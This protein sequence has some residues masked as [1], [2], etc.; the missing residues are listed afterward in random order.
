[1]DLD[2]I[3]DKLPPKPTI[4]YSL[5]RLPSLSL[6]PEEVFLDGQKD[7]AQKME[8]SFKKKNFAIFYV[9]VILIFVLLAG[10]AGWLQVVRGAFYQ[11]QAE[12][13]RT[14]V[15][16]ILAP[17]GIIY[18]RNQKQLVYNVP[19]FDAVAVPA[20]LPK[21]KAVREELIKKVSQILGKDPED[22]GQIIKSAEFFSFDPIIIESDIDHERAVMLEVELQNL[23]GI[24][25]EK[26]LRREYV[27]APSFSHILGYVGRMDDNDIKA[28]QDY[29]LTETVGKNGLELWYED[30]LHTSPGR[31]KL[32]VDAFGSIKKELDSFEPQS[33]K[34][35]VLSIDVDLQKFIYDR[36]SK[37]L[38]ELRLSKAAA[39]ALNPQNGQIMALASLPGFDSNLLAGGMGE[40]EYLSFSQ[41]PE[42]PLFNRAI[43]GQYPPGS[44]I[45]PFIGAA[46]LEEKI[47]SANT[48]INDAG[49]LFIGSYI[50][51]DWKVHG[52]VNIYSA[53]AQSCNVFF[54]HVGG[55]YG[56]FSGLGV[57]GLEKYLKLFGFGRPTGIDLPNEKDGFVPSADWKKEK[58]G[59][60][61][62]IGDTYHLSIGQGDITVT[63]LQ[64]AALTAVI[65]NSGTIWQPQIVDKIVDAEKNIIE[66]IKP[67]GRAADFISVK[68]L[69]IIKEA[70][71]QT[72]RAGS[73]Q[74]LKSLSIAVAGK[75]GTAQTSKDKK[76]Q[77]WFTSFAPFDKPEIVLVIL[78]EEGG[79]GS[80]VAVPIAKDVLEWYFQR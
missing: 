70:M 50:Y 54:Y 29:F 49:P 41:N 3:F 8:A 57:D 43:S 66:D 55:G 73:A 37:S 28:H 62:Y 4:N 53:I 51:P 9:F 27:L 5:K 48:T 40:K 1:M 44:T 61:W 10:K 31:Q 59:E 47:I 26:N 25:L 23:S 38:K 20:Y 75:T 13:N 76:P 6:E 45:K 79:E 18:D 60:N 16:P 33:A 17:R 63:P 67:E 35:L 36:I 46:A 2:Q 11:L 77:A 19:T 15:V 65:A 52:P 58:R 71:R 21:N 78:V 24:S 14:R 42:Q 32:E 64:M 72:V 56:D 80:S 7:E 39:V 69:G 68:N 30:V 12:K 34:N 74:Y 22:L